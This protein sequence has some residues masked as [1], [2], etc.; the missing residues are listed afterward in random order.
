MNPKKIKYK[1]K[2]LRKKAPGKTEIYLIAAIAIIFVISISIYRY[3]LNNYNY[4]K[5]DIG[6]QLVYTSFTNN[7]SKYLKEVP[8]VNIKT[9]NIQNINSEISKFSNKYLNIEKSVLTY[10]YNLNGV[11]LSI[12]LKAS[13]F[14]NNNIPEIEFLSYNINLDTETIIDNETLFSY[15]EIDLNY[16][17][18]KL[19]HKFKS[20]YQQLVKEGYFSSRECN[21]KCFLNTRGIDKYTDNINYY[22]NDGKLYAY[23]PFFVISIYGEEDFFKEENFI[24]E[25]S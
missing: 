17:N 13:N 4:L 21:Y 18:N 9:E 16:I 20:Y 14:S 25:I 12:I 24:F 6:K 1:G 22:I 5:Q 11:I 8:Y 3:M 23:K 10:E 2:K 19:E 15:Y 7:T